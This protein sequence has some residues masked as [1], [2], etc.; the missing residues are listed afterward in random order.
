M[1]KWVSGAPTM[2][3]AH[4]W[5]VVKGKTLEVF[6]AEPAH[7]SAAQ[8]RRK[9]ISPMHSIELSQIIVHKVTTKRSL[10]RSLSSRTGT[11]SNASRKDNIDK[12]IVCMLTIERKGTFKGTWMVQCQNPE[13]RDSWKYHIDRCKQ[14]VGSHVDHSAAA[15]R[16]LGPLLQRPV[17][18]ALYMSDRCSYLKGIRP[19]DMD[20]YDDYADR[21]EMHARG[22][23]DECN[24]MAE[25]EAVL[26][27]CGTVL[28]SHSVFEYALLGKKKQ[29]QRPVR[30][31]FVIPVRAAPFVALHT[32]L[33]CCRVLFLK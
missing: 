5:F 32:A 10:V 14:L 3:N 4:S 21:F 23:M 12:D 25:A 1:L 19:L 11:E 8:T 22:I 29:V 31:R 13:E 15:T 18:L 28:F 27:G 6:Q 17:E 24:S 2:A 16:D 30:A 26:R 7:V 20:I 9:A 33:H